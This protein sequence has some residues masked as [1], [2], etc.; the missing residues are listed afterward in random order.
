MYFDYNNAM[1]VIAVYA[2]ASKDR[3]DKRVSTSRQVARGTALAEALFPG[4]PVRTYVDNDKS[5]GDPD[6]VRDGYNQL[7]ADV[8]AGAVAQVVCHE[9]SRLT[10]IPGVWDDLVVTLTKAGITKVH[11]VQNGVVAVEP[12][13][14]LVGRIM[15]VIDAEELERIKARTLAAHAQLAAE[16]R[17]SGARTYGYRYVPGADGRSTLVIK[18]A[19]AKVVR[20]ICNQLIAG[21]SLSAIG[22]ELDAAG[23][24]T[25]RGGSRWRTGT[26]KSAVARPTVAGLRGHHGDLTPGTWEAI[27]TEERW[28][29]ALRALGAKTVID[30]GGQ[31]RPSNRVHRPARR[32][33]LLTGGLA[34]CGVCDSPMLVAPK[35]G[36]GP[37]M[38][39]CHHTK[40]G[41]CGRVSLSPAEVVEQLVVEQVLDALDKPKLAKRLIEHPDPQRAGLLADLARAQ[42]DMRQAAERKDSG[43]IDWETFDA[44]HDPAKA[45]AEAARAALAALPDPDVELPPADQVRERWEEMPLRQKRAVLE[46][47]L[48]AVEVLPATTRGRSKLTT[49]ERVDARLELKWR[50]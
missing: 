26:V 3:E 13:N 50:Q 10:R 6:V 7:I 1:H 46:R 4:V 24:P 19:E 12:G 41:A 15:S 2:R 32:R 37:S 27:V 17:P 31:R 18:P 45:R 20:L 5:G 43:R 38:Y 21:H 25:P 9:Q 16:G 34:R 30:A 49:N 47:F 23:V 39:V 29:K 36:G 44:L 22:A 35:R 33:W 28:R 14:R 42:E 8:R 11:T 40:D 48:E